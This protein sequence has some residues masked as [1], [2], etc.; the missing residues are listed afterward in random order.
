SGPA[1]RV[2]ARPRAPA[3][4]PWS[5]RRR[6][7]SHPSIGRRSRAPVDGSIQPAPGHRLG[8]PA[9][10]HRRPLVRLIALNLGLAASFLRCSSSDQRS[11]VRGPLVPVLR[12]AFSISAFPLAPAFDLSVLF[13]KLAVM[14]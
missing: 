3:A 2:A 8:L 12:S 11:V 4:N 14:T 7:Q 1:P 10:L 5:L 6:N 9:P 13:P